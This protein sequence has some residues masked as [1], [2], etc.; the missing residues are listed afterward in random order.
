MMKRFSQ[1]SV[2]SRCKLAIAQ[3]AEAMGID[4]HLVTYACSQGRRQRD[5]AYRFKPAV[6]GAIFAQA[7]E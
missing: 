1:E 4:E 3:L 5:G 6:S 2:S 7:A